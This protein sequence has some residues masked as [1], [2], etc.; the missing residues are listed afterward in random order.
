[1]SMLLA[2]LPLFAADAPA[3]PVV[4]LPSSPELG[5]AEGKCHA[6]EA[7]PALLVDVSGLKD[8]VGKLKLEVYPSNDTDF[9]MDDNVLIFQGK[10]FRRVEEDVPQSG[11]VQLCVRVPGPGQYSVTLLHDRDSNRKFGWWVDGIGF[12][13]NPTLGWHKPKAAATRVTAGPGLSHITIV[14]N[15]RNGLGVSPINSGN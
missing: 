3:K 13:A 2:L 7:G 6:G 9:L 8:R 4:P 10:T 14:L 5:K 1:M 12:G 15:Y 11:P